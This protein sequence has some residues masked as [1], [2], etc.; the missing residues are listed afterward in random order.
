VEI[1]KKI[2]RT[3]ER[4]TETWAIVGAAIAVWLAARTRRTDLVRCG[5]RGLLL[6]AVAGALGGAIVA[7]AGHLPTANS[8]ALGIDHPLGKGSTGDWLEI[9]SVAITGGLIG[10]IIGGIWRPPSRGMG[11]ISGAGAG[12][13]IGLILLGVGWNPGAPA[14]AALTFC[15]RAAVIAGFVVATLALAAESAR[16][17]AE[18]G[19][20]AAERAP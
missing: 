8:P 10:G 1:A 12:A 11:F 9:A 15:I 4:R 20:A 2:A 14:A 7:F 16:G 19:A 3:I 5:L 13:L 18:P 17:R 6:G